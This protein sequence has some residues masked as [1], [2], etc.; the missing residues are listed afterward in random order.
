MRCGPPCSDLPQSDEP[1]IE[2]SLF[3]K[4]IRAG[5]DGLAREAPLKRGR[6]SY[7]LK[8]ASDE[9]AGQPIQVMRH[10]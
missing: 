7:Q 3:E 9:N 2:R 8:E 6:L 1:L 5:P 4:S 10:M